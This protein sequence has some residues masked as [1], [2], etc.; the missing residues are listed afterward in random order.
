[1]SPLRRGVDIALHFAI[2]TA[3][4]GVVAWQLARFFDYR[5]NL[6]YQASMI[7]KV[8][9]DIAI[10]MLVGTLPDYALG[11]IKLWWALSPRRQTARAL[12]AA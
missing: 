11:L 3:I 12:V 2:P 10:L 9:P 5:F 8:L 4:L 6:V 7:F 1:M